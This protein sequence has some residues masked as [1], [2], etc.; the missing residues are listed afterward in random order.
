MYRRFYNLTRYPFELGPDP[1]FFYATPSHKEVLVNLVYGIQRHKGFI[2]VTGEVGTGKTLLVH[3]LLELLRRTS[4][5]FVY[6]MNPQLSSS[7]LIHYLLEHLKLPPYETPKNEGLSRLHR[8]LVEQYRRGLTCA[9]VVDEAH[10]L[11]WK[12]LEEI[13]LLG[14]LE[15]TRHKL[16]QVVLIGQPELD[17]KIDSPCCRQVKQRVSLRCHL[18]ALNEE[19]TRKYIIRRL[20]LAGANSTAQ[21]L[22]SAEAIAAIYQYSR[23]IPRV[24]NS[25]CENALIVG[26]S[27]QACCIGLDLIEEV[28]GSLH[29]PGPHEY[30][31]AV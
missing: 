9:L 2:A 7:E 15:T 8:Y 10:L 3:C 21:G 31:V 1:F 12:L 5:P 29:L 23:G 27:C 24:V 17:R 4:I 22:F 18:S 14:N 25:I 28:S 26:Y 20:E 16:L 30:K 13:R 19:E 6:V 11:S